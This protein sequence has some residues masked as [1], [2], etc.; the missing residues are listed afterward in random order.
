MGAAVLLFAVA[1]G[2]IGAA[3]S[4]EVVV[5]PGDDVQAIVDRSPSGTTFR[6]TPGVYRGV[7]ITPKDKDTFIGEPGAVLNGS[8]L[9]KFQRRGNFWVAA[10]RTNADEEDVMRMG[11]PIQRPGGGG[12]GQGGAQNQGGGQGQGGRPRG[13]GFGGPGGRIGFP[14]GGGQG[15]RQGG[16]AG[17][18]GNQANRPTQSQYRGR[19]QEQF[20][21]CIFPED[22]FIDDKPLVRVQHQDE[23][24]PQRWY[25]DPAAGEIYVADDPTGHKVEIG[26]TRR[27]FSGSANG[28]TIRGLIIEKYAQ[29]AGQAAVDGKESE[30]WT[31]EQNEIRWNHAAGIRAATGWKVLNNKTHHNGQ[32]G[33]GGSGRDILVEGNETYYNNFAGYWPGWEAGGAKFVMTENLVVRNNFAHDNLGPGL[34]TD[35][36]N[37]NTLYEGNR[38][39]NNTEGI[40]HEISFHAVIRN[41]TVWNDGNNNFGRREADAGILIGESRDVEVYG[42]TV[43]NCRNGILG[44]QLN[45]R[46]D[47]EMYHMPEP[48][49]IHNLYVHDNVITQSSGVAVGIVKPAPHV[50]DD[51]F[52]AWGN[53]IEHNTFQLADPNGDFFAWNN[54]RYNQQQWQK[55]MKER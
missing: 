10:G 6:F 40:F 15:R 7:S 28:V 31:V 2:L 24:G 33:M 41:N 45:R 1:T 20:P 29:A 48:Y 35:I 14:G 46:P 19:C 37:K 23:L 44:R 51:V 26:A 30:N 27:A 13:G 4:K 11:L 53:R 17:R 16:G 18:G 21:L 39:T 50:S 34:W 8:E 22:V 38:T 47:A 9:L 54:N 42:N 3:P 36:N 52:T 32:A 5:K 49:E 12:D 25:S 55:M 43:K